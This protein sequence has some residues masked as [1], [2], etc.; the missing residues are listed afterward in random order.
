MQPLLQS[1]FIS[2][3]SDG[4]PF[5]PESPAPTQDVLGDTG[6]SDWHLEM[7]LFPPAS[8]MYYPLIPAVHLLTIDLSGYSEASEYIATD[9][10]LDRNSKA[11]NHPDPCSIFIQTGPAHHICQLSND[12]AC[13]IPLE[14]NGRSIQMAISECTGTDN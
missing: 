5:V 10:A 13:A 14:G 11:G 3:P 4:L 6:W 1:S 8:S 9:V 7:E 12:V 2:A